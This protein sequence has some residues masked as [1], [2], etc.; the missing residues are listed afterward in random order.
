MELSPNFGKNLIGEI[1]GKKYARIPV[2]THLITEKDKDIVLLIKKY[3]EG[4]LEKGDTVFISEKIIAIIQGRACPIDKIRPSKIAKVL[5]KFVSKRPGGIGLALPETMQ[6]AIEEV[7]ITRILLAALGA[8]LTKPFGIK[9][10]FYII[11]GDQAR[12]VDGPTQNTIPPYNNY[13]IK[14]PLFPNQVAEKISKEIKTPVAIVDVNDWGV[15]IL[16]QSQ[17]FK[18]DKTTLLKGLKDNP[19]GQCAEST[20]IGI[21]RK[22][23]SF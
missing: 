22:I 18:V 19:L 20:P 13:A 5:S 14:G 12:A 23:N 7:G 11:A 8:V 15:R 1:E 17:T 21:F 3:L 16:G 4:I 2:K 6:L 9:G 10:A